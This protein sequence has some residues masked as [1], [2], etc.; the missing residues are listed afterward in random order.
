VTGR[1]GRPLNAD[2]ALWFT[3]ENVGQLG[4]ITV[5][6]SI[7]EYPLD[8]GW[9]PTGIAADAS[10]KV[11]FTEE[12]SNVIGRINANKPN[13][14]GTLKRFP[15]PTDGAL[16]CDITLGQDGNMWFTELAGRNIG[17]I[18]PKGRIKEFPV[19][20]ESGMAGIHRRSGR[21]HLV[22]RGVRGLHRTHHPELTATSA[23]PRAGTG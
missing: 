13:A 2:D 7:T 9:F 11:W 8:P 1:A 21:E 16:P 17:R 6:G 5:D 15:V 19:P 20:G 22:L 18:K 12:L 23:A 4:R 10:G 14:F 3:E